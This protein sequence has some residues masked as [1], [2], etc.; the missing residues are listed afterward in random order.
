MKIEGMH[1]LGC[2]QTPRTLGIGL[3]HRPL[4]CI[5]KMSVGRDSSLVCN[6]LQQIIYE[7]GDE[8]SVCLS[9]LPLAEVNLV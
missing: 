9:S 7:I 3:Y 5:P 1:A 4:Y 2:E 6:G 8:G